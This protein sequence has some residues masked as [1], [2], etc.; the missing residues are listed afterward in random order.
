MKALEDIDK[1]FEDGSLATVDNVNEII[2]ALEKDAKEYEGSK[3]Y[4]LAS[5]VFEVADCEPITVDVIKS[6][7]HTADDEGSLNGQLILVDCSVDSS[8][9]IM[10]II[11][12]NNTLLI[13]VN[14][15]K[16]SFNKV[17]LW[18]QEV[19]DGYLKMSGNSFYVSEAGKEVSKFAMALS[20]I[21]DFIPLVGEAKSAY[22][23]C[24]GRDAITGEE[25]GKVGQ[26]VS[27]ICALPLI[28]Y[29][30]KGMKAFK[31]IKEGKAAFAQRKMLSIVE[32]QVEKGVAK[33]SGKVVSLSNQTKEQ[34][35]KSKKAFEKL[36][37]EHKAKLEKYIENPD[38]Y[39]NLSHLKNAQ[40][41][42]IR[43]KKIL[44]RIKNLETQI[45]GQEFNLKE[46]IK[47]I[48]EMN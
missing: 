21:L 46:I 35:L 3:N 36:I 40:T 45:K 9:Q 31:A 43:Q 42:E 23:A 30:K 20:I 38:A 29:A 39:D 34:L 6:S 13:K 19:M 7:Q 27:A 26:V 25:I 32:R 24:S 1:V 22:E 8:T 17:F 15:Q 12:K 4:P 10:D 2:E 37:L 44:G 47:L 14:G 18:R 41:P 48:E 5:H 16:E 33:K 28:G 11:Y